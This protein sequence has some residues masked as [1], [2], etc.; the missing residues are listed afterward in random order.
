MSVTSEKL[1]LLVRRI[2]EAYPS[3]NYLIHRDGMMYRVLLD[4]IDLVDSNEFTEFFIENS[5]DIF[6]D[7]A[8]YVVSLYDYFGIITDEIEDRKGRIK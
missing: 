3:P 7:D 2:K 4:D 8:S 1:N 5:I 6:G